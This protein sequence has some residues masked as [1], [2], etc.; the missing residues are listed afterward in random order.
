M[1]IDKAKTLFNNRI[2]K[3]KKHAEK[4]MDEMFNDWDGLHD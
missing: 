4:S 1:E 3:H 2:E